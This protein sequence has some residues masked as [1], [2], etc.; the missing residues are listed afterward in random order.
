MN[1]TTQLAAAFVT[2][3]NWH[4][5]NTTVWGEPARADLHLH[6]HRIARR[7]ATGLYITTAGWNTPTTRARLNGLPGVE[8]R[9]VNGQ[10]MLNGKPWSG[11][12]TKIGDQE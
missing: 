6:G 3:Y 8:V 12:W 2:G 1:Q 11:E 4:S 9:V 5:G 7:D 10:L